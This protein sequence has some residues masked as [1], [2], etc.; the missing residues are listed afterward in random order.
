M[1]NKFIHRLINAMNKQILHSPVSNISI[2]QKTI[3]FCLHLSSGELESL[4]LNHSGNKI[5]QSRFKN[6]ISSSNKFSYNASITYPITQCL[7]L[8][9]YTFDSEKKIYN[10]KK[11]TIN[12]KRNIGNDFSLIA[13]YV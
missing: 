9:G 1:S 6:H 8:V 5:N 10:S 2:F 12:L 7:Y 3:K 13:A 11:I 4:T